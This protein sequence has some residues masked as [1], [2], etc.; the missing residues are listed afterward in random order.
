MATDVSQLRASLAGHPAGLEVGVG[1]PAAVLADTASAFSGIDG[2]LLGATVLVV[3][4]LLLLTYRSLFLWLFPLI[5]VGLATLLGQAGVYLLARGGFVVNGMTIG[6]LTVLMFGAGTDYSLLLVARYRE[7]LRSEPQPARAMA[8]APERVAPTLAV[9]AST[10]ILKPPG[11]PGGP[12]AGYQGAGPG[13]GDRD[14]G[15][16]AR[17]PH[18]PAASPADVRQVRIL[19]AS[20]QSRSSASGSPSQLAPYR[21]LGCV[22]PGAAGGRWDRGVGP[23]LPGAPRIPS[24]PATVE[25]LQRPGAVGYGANPHL[26][27]LPGREHQAGCG[28]D[29]EPG[30][31]SGRREPGRR[32]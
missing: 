2:I 23:A 18:P 3:T 5:T 22:P 10:V 29:R 13:G 30:A 7:E 11:A 31:A 1:G 12:G 28:G 9:S 14:R 4:V 24:K 15:G 16:A 19:A 25:G 6:I 8:I 21:R 20:A 32:R 17:E 27:L 26:Q